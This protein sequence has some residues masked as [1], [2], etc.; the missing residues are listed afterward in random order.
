MNPPSAYQIIPQ[1]RLQTRLIGL[2][3]MISARGLNHNTSTT[4]MKSLTL[5]LLLLLHRAA[6]VDPSYCTNH[7]RETHR[8]HDSRGVVAPLPCP[9][10]YVAHAG[11][12]CAGRY[13]STLNRCHGNSQTPLWTLP[14]A[15]CV[16]QNPAWSGCPGNMFDG[17]CCSGAEFVGQRVEHGNWKPAECQGGGTVVFS[18][19]TSKNGQVSTYTPPPGLRSVAGDTYMVGVVVKPDGEQVPVTVGDLNRG[20]GTTSTPGAPVQTG[21]PGAPGAPANQVKKAGSWVV[22][23]DRGVV[24]MSGFGAAG[25]IVIVLLL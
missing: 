13:S 3:P 8:S 25:A 11:I 2:L 1:S 19:T 22:R 6:A 21:A 4:T 18:V 5:P 16:S 10:E 24:L 17:L 23:P 7:P 15:P 12:C 20:V 14:L 9:G